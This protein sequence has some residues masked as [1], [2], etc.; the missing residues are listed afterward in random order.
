LDL[1]LAGQDGEL[2]RNLRA[3]LAGY[4]QTRQR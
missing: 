1:A 4:Q 2:V 3:K